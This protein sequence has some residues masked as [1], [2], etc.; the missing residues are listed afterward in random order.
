MHSIYWGSG[1]VL[2]Y[3][4]DDKGPTI[5]FF[6]TLRVVVLRFL[7]QNQPPA[8]GEEKLEKPRN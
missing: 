4:N 5:E 2:I 3:V 7:L 8:Y 6:H 1:C